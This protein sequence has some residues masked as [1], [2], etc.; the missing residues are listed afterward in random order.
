MK[1]ALLQ[2]AADLARQT[3]AVLFAT[4][5]RHGRPHI[6]VAGKLSLHYG[7][8]KIVLQEWFCPA[9]I[10]NL[11]HRRAISLVVWDVQADS[12]YQ[13][14]G[15]VEAIEETAMLD[16]YLADEPQPPPSQVRRDL[17]IDPEDI[18]P[19]SRRPHSDTPSFG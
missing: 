2:A 1:E 9:T 15:Q 7:K 3:G 10:A 17:L 5:D 19:F 12:G 6:G 18:L 14:L 4:A 8:Q 11:A 16:G 13:I